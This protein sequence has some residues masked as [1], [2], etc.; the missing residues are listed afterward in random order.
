[1]KTPVL[2]V[3]RRAAVMIMLALSM[4]G[5]ATLAAELAGATLP[6]AA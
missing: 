6:D 1:M 3:L 2:R 5:T 4:L